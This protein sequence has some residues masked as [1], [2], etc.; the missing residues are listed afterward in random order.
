MNQMKYCFLQV[1]D[2]LLNP[3]DSNNPADVYFK[4]IWN[5]LDGEGYFKPPHFWELPLWIAELS[6]CLNSPDNELMLYHID[7][8][9]PDDCPISSQHDPLLP[10]ADIYFASVMD[11]NKEI[12]RTIIQNNPDK[13]FYLGG[14]MGQA[15]FIRYFYGLI[16]EN[17]NVSWYKD[18]PAVCEKLN[19]D[20]R[21]GTDYRLFKGVKC[22]PRLTLSNG[23]INHCKFCTLP[24]EIT[25]MRPEQIEQQIQSMENLDFELVYINDKTF[26]QAPNYH[27][28]KY[29]YAM[30]KELNPKFQG[31]IVQTTC[32]QI[33]KFDGQGVN[34]K[35]LGIV[36]VE[37][38]V[39]SYNNVILKKY[40]KPQ[41]TRTIDTALNILEN[42]G[43]NIIPNIIIGL[44]GENRFT[45]WA[46]LDWLEENKQNFLMLNV[47][48]FVSY[49]GNGFHLIEQDF[50]EN[51]TRRSYHTKKE[52][53]TIRMF[54][55]SLFDIAMEIIE[56]TKGKSV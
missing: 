37:I 22:I 53:S 34:L 2:N 15:E 10:D 20:Y 8:I 3:N 48:N 23:C 54:T 31:F 55:E 45:Y 12:L 50:N 41:N 6:Y 1:S 18:M 5:H 40:S 21:Y 28:L 32:Y 49:D 14:H 7:E 56:A 26:G 36:N 13:Q 25:T 46:T 52:A 44:P 47:T 51:S 35:D 16:V 24:V 19:L 17:A 39:E 38:G 27:L 11:C 33:L 9:C 42:A 30:I 43:V 4:T 29:F